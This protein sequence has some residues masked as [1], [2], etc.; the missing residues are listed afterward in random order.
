LEA[1]TSDLWLSREGAEADAEPGRFLSTTTFRYE[2]FYL[3]GWSR[4]P[5]TD[6]VTVVLCAPGADDLNGVDLLAAAANGSRHISTIDIGTQSGADGADFSLE[7]LKDHPLPSLFIAVGND[8]RAVSAV[9]NLAGQAGIE[10]LHAGRASFPFV[11]NDEDGASH[12]CRTYGDLA[13]HLADPA[14]TGSRGSL[15]AADAGWSTYWRLVAR[16]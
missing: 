10:C 4:R 16:R 8:L 11:L 1:S 5:R 7:P 13:A 15:Q 3:R 9:R 12:L 14:F 2:P 6:D